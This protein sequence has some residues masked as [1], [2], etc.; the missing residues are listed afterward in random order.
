M[1]TF[2]GVLGSDRLWHARN[3][4]PE[5]APRIGTDA[6]GAAVERLAY[7][8]SDG[9]DASLAS[10]VAKIALVEQESRTELL[11]HRFRALVVVLFLIYVV[12]FKRGARDAASHSGA[13]TQSDLRQHE[14]GQYNQLLHGGIHGEPRHSI[15]LPGH[16]S[17]VRFSRGCD[18]AFPYIAI[19]LRGVPVAKRRPPL[20]VTSRAPIAAGPPNRCRHRALRALVSRS[21]C[22]P[23]TSAKPSR[24]TCFNQAR[25]RP[26]AIHSHSP[27]PTATS[28]G[29]F[30]TIVISVSDDKLSAPTI[31]GAP[32]T[33]V[34][35]GTQ[36]AFQPTAS[37]VNGDVLTFSIVNKPAWATFTTSTG[38]STTQGSRATS[39]ATWCQAR[40][41]S[42]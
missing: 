9:P 6:L 3:G 40:S 22:P 23:S 1:G 17:N 15:D 5:N 37:D 29:N 38:R 10:A 34:V 18:R 11:P 28:V 24:S 33:S 25:R 41:S 12:L 36:Y 2:S 4:E 7:A 13:S 20:R 19:E 21:A 14:H 39:S 30:A 31:S 16:R 26:T 27:S 32:P 8:G 35:Q 42:W